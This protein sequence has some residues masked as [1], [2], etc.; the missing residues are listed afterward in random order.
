MCS[1]AR[2]WQVGPAV[3][4]VLCRGLGNRLDL[5]WSWHAAEI[6]CA[7]VSSEEGYSDFITHGLAMTFHPIDPFQTILIIRFQMMEVQRRRDRFSSRLRAAVGRITRGNQVNY[8]GPSPSS[9]YEVAVE[10]QTNTDLEEGRHA[11]IQDQLS[12]KVPD[13]IKPIVERNGTQEPQENAVQ[14]DHIFKTINQRSRIEFHVENTVLEIGAAPVIEASTRPLKEEEPKQEIEFDFRL[15]SDET[16]LV[17]EEEAKTN[18]DTQSESILKEPKSKE[19]EQLATNQKSKTDTSGREQQT[20]VLFD[21]TEEAPLIYTTPGYEWASA[22]NGYDWEA[23]ERFYGYDN[24]TMGEA[25][26]RQMERRREI[27][28]AN[29]TKL[30]KVRQGAAGDARVVM[31]KA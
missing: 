31:F 6:T 16:T 22:S 14:T 17:Q 28:E 26:R 21:R 20:K 18:P 15:Y 10:N 1:S 19:K 5:I 11:I 27:T 12:V 23:R 29:M 3:Q 2:K 7:T 4:W 24:P 25:Y 30:G 8:A 13:E 9:F